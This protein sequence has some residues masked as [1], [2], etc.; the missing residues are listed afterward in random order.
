MEDYQTSIG[1]VLKMGENAETASEIPGLLDFPDML[2]E[3]D[4]IEVTTMKDK[5]RKY[6]PGLSDPGDMAFTFGYEGMKTGT[7]WATLK[8]AKG[9]DKVFVLLFPDGSGFKW[10]GGVSLSMPG[11]GVA[12]A[13]TFTA[14]ITPSSDIEEYNSSDY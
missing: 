7:N 1:V 9:T 12:E 4:K 6:K 5:Q 13:L 3:A 10:T 11:K 8:G 14:K 2:G